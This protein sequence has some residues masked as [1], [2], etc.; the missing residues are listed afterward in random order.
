MDVVVTLKD[1]KESLILEECEFN[2]EVNVGQRII[3]STNYYDLPLS[4]R[5]NFVTK[6][7]DWT[8]TELN[9]I[10]KNKTNG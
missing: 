4:E 6:L 2:I 3:L 9:N 5:Q 10:S 8:E 7:K 1:I